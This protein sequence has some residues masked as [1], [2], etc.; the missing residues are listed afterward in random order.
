MPTD[1]HDALLTT[2]RH[3]T[4]RDAWRGEDRGRGGLEG[5]GLSACRMPL[6]RSSPLCG[7]RTDGRQR[8]PRRRSLPPPSLPYP[9]L[10]PPYPAF[11]PPYRPLIPPPPLTPSLPTAYFPS[12][13]AFLTPPPPFHLPPPPL[14]P[15]SPPLPLPPPGILG[16]CHQIL[17]RAFDRSAAVDGGGA[18]G[19]RLEGEGLEGEGAAERES[20][21]ELGAAAFGVWRSVY[22]S[23]PSHC[24]PTTPPPKRPTTPPYP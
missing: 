23:T 7:W 17:T 6:T 21:L 9:R 13:S 1:A 10:H 16:S 15:L 8:A 19:G 2:R 12:S 22:P 18:A 5:G 14:P 4:E 11:S 24:P 20:A 3:R